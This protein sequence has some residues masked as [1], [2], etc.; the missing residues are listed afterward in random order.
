MTLPMPVKLKF[1]PF[2]MEYPSST[3][4]D[5]D[6]CNIKIHKQHLLVLRIG[7][8]YSVTHTLNQIST[9]NVKRGEQPYLEM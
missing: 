7:E 1:G 2:I 3:R 8:I 4:W 6:V 5:V 9:S